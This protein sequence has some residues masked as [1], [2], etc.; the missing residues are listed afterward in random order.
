MAKLT[1]TMTKKNYVLKSGTKTVFVETK[2]ET[3]TITEKEYNN[4]VEAAP[5]FRRLG[6]SETLRKSYTCAGYLVTKVTSKNPN[7]DEMTT[8]DFDFEYDYK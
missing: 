6:G 4:I 2:T 8:R 5:F 1:I 7:R 3:T